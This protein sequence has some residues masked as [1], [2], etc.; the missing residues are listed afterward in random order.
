MSPGSPPTPG[1]LDPRLTDPDAAGIMAAVNLAGVGAPVR[2]LGTIAEARS[3]AVEPV[4]DIHAFAVVSRDLVLPGSATLRVRL[5]TPTATPAHGTLVYLH[6]GGWALGGLQINDGVC[7]ELCRSAGVRIV[8]VD[9]RL[10]P[11][12]PFPAALE[13]AAEV[14]DWVAQGAPGSDEEFSGGIGVAG[15]S[16]GAAL[17]AALARRSR[18]GLAPAVV[19]Q[20][21][22]CPVLDADFS[23]ESYAANA[24]GLLLTAADMRWFWDLYLP[25]HSARRDPDAAPGALRDLAGLP[26]ATL[27]IAGADPLRDEAVDYADRLALA[28]VDTDMHL[29]DGVMH[30]FPAFPG[31]ESGQHALRQAAAGVAERLVASDLGESYGLR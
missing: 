15:L 31:I 17:A 25:D 4:V 23:R 11:E 13:D 5:Y 21:L 7:R 18:D 2:H 28:G 26:P 6:G 16:A 30:A 22:I 20:L 1:T 3:L 9:Y 8:S 10:A 14:L 19:Q 12:H 29:V 27:I 24:E